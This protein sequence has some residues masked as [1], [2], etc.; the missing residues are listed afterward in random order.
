MEGEPA[1]GE[2]AGGEDEAEDAGGGGGGEE[3]GVFGLAGIDDGLEAEAAAVAGGTAGGVVADEGA[4]RGERGR[5]AEPGEKVGERGGNA[6]MEELLKAARAPHG[7]EFDEV[8]VGGDEALGG[9]HD[10]RKKADEK[11]DD[12]DAL[13]AG[14]DPND[15][16]G[17]EDDHGGHLQNHQVGVEADADE[18][19]EG[20]GER[21]DEADGDG[22]GEAEEGALRGVERGAREGIGVGAKGLEDRHG[23]GQQKAQVF[24]EQR[25]DAIPQ[26]ED[27]STGGGGQKNV[28]EATGH[29]RSDGDV[30]DGAENP[31]DVGDEVVVGA[32]EAGFLG[33]RV[34]EGDGNFGVHVA[35]VGRHY[36]NAVGQKHGFGDGVG[37][38]KGGPGVAFADGE[39]FLVEVFAGHLV[40]GAEG[41]VEEEDFGGQGEGAGDGHAHF[42]AAGKLAGIRVGFFGEADELEDAAAGGGAFGGRNAAQGER[43]F[44]IGGHRQPREERRLLEDEREVGGGGVRRTTVDREGAGGVRG[45]AGDE[46]EQ[47]GFAAA[48][49]A[50]EGNEITGLRGEADAVEHERAVAEA[51]E[52]VLEFDD[53]RRHGHGWGANVER[54]GA[55]SKCRR[56]DH[57][58]AAAGADSRR[59]RRDDLATSAKKERKPAGG[60]DRARPN[61]CSGNQRT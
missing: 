37:D 30:L 48:A 10:E 59:L 33:A 49:G 45:E 13:E 42:L 38:E 9:V 51:F 32:G 50:D 16:D 41:F 36:A 40:E 27:E 7:E 6:E 5:D 56:Q 29:A 21:A 61:R 35:G 53:G 60:D 55:R 15:E 18:G 46:A 39:E 44:D 31:G 12:R 47:R 1:E 3:G 58:G 25:V 2:D 57:G 20:E 8:A 24:R 52:D 23:R 14:A 22:E 26:C 34:R 43:E 19:R 17:R 4:D 54:R 28:L 11:R